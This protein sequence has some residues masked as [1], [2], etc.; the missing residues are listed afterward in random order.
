MVPFLVLA[1]ISTV[2]P[3]STGLPSELNWPGINQFCDIAFFPDIRSSVTSFL[4]AAR[5][6]HWY[7]RTIASKRDLAHFEPMVK[8]KPIPRLFVRLALHAVL[9]GA[10]LVMIYA[11]LDRIMLW[12]GLVPK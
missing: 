5:S 3:F 11:A 6:W 12:L 9:S 8:D 7:S 10:G 2:S 1:G 4:P